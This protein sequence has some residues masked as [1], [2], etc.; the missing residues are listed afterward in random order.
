MALVVVKLLTQLPRDL[1]VKGSI[2]VNAL[3]SNLLAN[4]SPE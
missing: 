4:S 2:L 1:D 3:L